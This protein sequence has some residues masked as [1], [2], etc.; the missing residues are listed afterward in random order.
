MLVSLRAVIAVAMLVG[1]YLLA[2]ALV[3]G[4]VALEVWALSASVLAGVK[5]GLF[6]VPAI[7]AVLAALVTAERRVD[8]ELA[9]VAV[10]PEQQPRLWE[11][12][13]RLADEVGT[14]A[15]DEIRVIAAVNAGVSESTRLLG[16]LVLR[17]RMYIG[18]PLLMCLT[19]KQLAAVLAHELGHY[20]NRDTRLAG[21]VVTGR[22]ALVRLVDGMNPEHLLQKLFAKL[23]LVYTKLYVR[24]SSAICRR[25]EFAADAVSA[26]IAGS[27]ATASALREMRVISVAWQL[28]VDRHLTVAWSAGYL[29]K[30][31]FDGF[32]LLRAA[33][34]LHPVLEDIRQEDADED[35]GPYDSH[36]PTAARIAAIEALDAQ[37]AREWDDR[38]A[39]ELVDNPVPLMDRSLMLTLV[40]DAERKKRVDWV[41]LGHIGVRHQIFLDTK[42][43]L[44]A[45]AN[46][47]DRDP[48]LGAVLDAL[49]ADRLADLAPNDRKPGDPVAGARARRELAREIVSQELTR[50]VL[51]AFVDARHARWHLDWRGQAH[52]DASGFDL[53]EVPDL[54]EAAVAERP[55]TTGLRELLAGAGIAADFRPARQ[56]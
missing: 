43:L 24:L 8:E 39:V 18:A 45:A 41:T 49:D 25:Q 15:P 1:F 5:I 23:F 9:G 42:R 34:E 55:D 33:P 20:G 35:R 31:M 29:P 30:T 54:V 10:T 36:P 44:N 11:L 12:V 28:F 3:G 52:L 40:A 4:L 17:R 22:D 47:L 53:T 16:L 32:A 13:H 26:R 37:P 14:R 51:L 56:S 2:L 27:S 50:L 7:F 38:P 21:V 6:V 46:V 48:S 19:E